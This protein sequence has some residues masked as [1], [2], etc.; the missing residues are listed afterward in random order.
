MSIFTA[1]KVTHDRVYEEAMRLSFPT[2]GRYTN[3]DAQ[4]F[5]LGLSCV[6]RS[7]YN[8]DGGGDGMASLLRSSNDA[9]NPSRISG[10]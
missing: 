7:T 10:L 1:R 3:D 4:R 9:I 5:T 6:L 2:N 8:P